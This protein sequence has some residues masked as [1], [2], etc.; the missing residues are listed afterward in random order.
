MF[1]RAPPAS[2]PILVGR[3]VI[4]AAAAAAVVWSFVP[5]RGP[6][7]AALR[8]PTADRY[9]CPM[10]PDVAASNPG[11][12]CPIC[13]MALERIAPA[14]GA[15][16][17][18]ADAQRRPFTR[19]ARAGAWV[20]P[21]GDIEAAFA[22]GDLVGLE[23]G[24]PAQFFRAAAP[25]APLAVNL[26]PGAPREWDRSRARV[27]LRPRP[28]LHAGDA[29]ETGWVVVAPITRDVLVVPSSAV[30]PSTD[31]PY[32]LVPSARD[33][34]EPRAVQV[35]KII[36]GVAIVLSG[37]REGDRVVVGDAFFVDA[38]R[39]LAAARRRGAEVSP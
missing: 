31:G 27:D 28:G 34:F 16:S 3:L 26:L 17:I 13:R 29:G 4:V 2:R 38:G 6:D 9:A 25:T 35:G 20:K 39:R 10:H 7:Q 11:G 30:L 1:D 23:P 33:G 21:D 32:V 36:D 14:A 5:T 19:E 18:T 8:T 24:Q 37:L 12:H 22:T 15:A